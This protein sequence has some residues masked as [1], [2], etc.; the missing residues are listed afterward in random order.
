MLRFRE[1]IS[2]HQA[3]NVI[4]QSL[5]HMGLTKYGFLKPKHLMRTIKKEESYLQRGSI[6]YLGWLLWQITQMRIFK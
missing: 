1:N 5:Q 2:K 4:N 3:Q 6:L